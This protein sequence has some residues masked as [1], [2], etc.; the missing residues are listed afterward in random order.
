MAKE[1]A[2]HEVKL[3]GVLEKTA[4]WARVL[5]D[6]RIE[7]EYYDFSS[8]AEDWFGH[9]IAWMYYVEAGEKSRICALLAEH[10]GV[11]IDGDRAMLDAMAANFRDVKLVRDWLKEKQIP[12]RQGFD[13]WA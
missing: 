4:S 12:I 11:R 6:G 10:T 7:L 1:N 5:D 8:D 9:D 13:S 3:Q 2:R